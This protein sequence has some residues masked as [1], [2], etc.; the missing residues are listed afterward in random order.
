MLFRTSST[1]ITGF[2]LYFFSTIS[3][4]I[5][6]VKHTTDIDQIFKYNDDKKNQKLMLIY[7]ENCQ[8]CNKIMPMVKEELSQVYPD[9]PIYLLNAAGKKNHFSSFLST[10]SITGFPTWLFVDTAN[11]KVEKYILKDYITPLDSL[12]TKINQ[13]FPELNPIWPDSNYI[14]DSLYNITFHNADNDNCNSINH[15]L[16]NIMDNDNCGGIGLSFVT[17]W[18]DIQLETLF[19]GRLNTIHRYYKNCGKNGTAA[20][21]ENLVL[22]PWFQLNGSD[23]IYSKLMS[24]FQISSFPTLV[25]LQKEHSHDNNSIIVKAFKLDLMYIRQNTRGNLDYSKQI[26]LFLGKYTLDRVD[27]DELT[28][29]I[30]KSEFTS[31]WINNS[32]HASGGKVIEPYNE[33]RRGDY[34]ED[35]YGEDDYGECDYGECDYGEDDYGEDDYEEEDDYYYKYLNEL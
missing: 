30:Q 24:I 5:I 13:V 3:A 22:F 14:V 25:V 15:I 18:L 12:V 2:L 16:H 7:S 32:L 10:Y 29:Y 9:L 28:P 11:D 27:N 34:G 33:D 20:T 35:D 17:P 6:E 26:E 4:H 23:G 8:W 31:D 1:I 19:H 21:K